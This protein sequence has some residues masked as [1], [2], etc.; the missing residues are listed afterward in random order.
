M[1]V[2]SVTS[3]EIECIS[4]RLRCHYLLLA[5]VILYASSNSHLLRPTLSYCFANFYKK[6]ITATQVFSTELMF[7]IPYFVADPIFS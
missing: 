5:K 7:V 2:F 6:Q 1:E 3:L 4:F